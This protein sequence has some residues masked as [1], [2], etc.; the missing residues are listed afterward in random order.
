MP[1]GGIPINMVLQTKQSDHVVYCHAAVL[2]VFSK[3]EWER[4]GVDGDPI[5]VLEEQE[6]QAIERFLRYWLSDESEQALYDPPGVEV[7]YIF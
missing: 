1:N 7:D 5:L 2:K 3:V 6:A 4:A